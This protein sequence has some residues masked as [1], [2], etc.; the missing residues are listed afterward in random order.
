MAK[1]LPLVE[2]EGLCSQPLVAGDGSTSHV[3]LFSRLTENSSDQALVVTLMGQEYV[4]PQNSAFLLSDFVRIQPLV[5]CECNKILK[6]SLNRKKKWT[7]IGKMMHKMLIVADSLQLGFHWLPHAKQP[8]CPQCKELQETCWT[9]A[10]AAC[11]PLRWEKFWLDSYWSALG[12][13]VCEEES[14]V[15]GHV[16]LFFYK[17]CYF[18]DKTTHCLPVYWNQCR[19]CFPVVTLFFFLVCFLYKGIAL[20]PQPSWNGYRFLFC[21]RQTVWSWPGSQTDRAT[22]N[23]SAMSFIHTGGWR[24][25]PSGSGSRYQ[26]FSLSKIITWPAMLSLISKSCLCPLPRSPHLES[27]S[28]HWIHLTR[29][30]TKFWC[31]AAAQINPQGVK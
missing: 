9:I 28:F 3:D 21:H 14:Q 16:E 26:S 11:L 15:I 17:T 8:Q 24:L 20:C 6:L 29:S 23:L 25:W 13:Q 18:V 1:E 7:K 22:C 31:W 5:Q 12:K 4:I 30:H 2:E 27:T 19:Q 10:K